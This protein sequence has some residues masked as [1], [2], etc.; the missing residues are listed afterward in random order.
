MEVVEVIFDTGKTSFE[1]LAKL[2][3][4]IHDPTQSDGQG[5]DIGNQYYSIIFY[6]NQEQKYIAQNLIDTLKG[7]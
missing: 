7:K 4:E 1:T 2:F 5:P 6:T 3:F